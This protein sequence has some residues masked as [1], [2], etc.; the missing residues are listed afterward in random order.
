MKIEALIRLIVFLAAVANQALVTLGLDA[1]PWS[2]DEIGAGASTLITVASGLWA[3]WKN[4]SVTKPAITAD[5]VLALIRDGTVT[6]DEIEDI[7]MP[8][9]FDSFSHEAPFPEDGRAEEV[10]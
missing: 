5:K 8:A 1:L 2:G 3:W 7:V 4:N 10:E 6:A 9:G